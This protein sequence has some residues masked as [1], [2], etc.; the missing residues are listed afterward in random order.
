M[1]NGK[2]KLLVIDG[3]SILNRAF[4][5]IRLLTNRDGLY[6]NAIYGFINI[7]LKQTEQLCPDYCAVAFDL[8][9]PTF[10][11]EMYEQYKAGR[12]GMPDELAVQL[13]YAKRCIELMGYTVLEK[14]GYEAD[15]I[16]GTLAKDASSSGCE[17]YILTGDRDS[18]QLIGEN[19][20]VL[21]ATNSETILYDESKFFEKY[22]IKTTQFV[23]LKALMGDSSDNIPGVAGIGEKTAIK[24]ISEFG[25]LDGLY[26]ALPSDKLSALVNSK[27]QN[28]KEN[29]YLSQKLAKIFDEV[30]EIIMALDDIAIREP[31]KKD[32]LSLFTELEFSGFIKRLNL[33]DPEK[34]SRDTLKI[35]DIDIPYLLKIDSEKILV[36]DIRDGVLT[37]CDG[38]AVYRLSAPLEETEKFFAS[39]RKFI[40]YDCKR[41]YKELEK[42]GVHFRNCMHDVMLGAYVLNPSE[43]SFELS[44]LVM[45]F[46]S[47]TVN[48]ETPFV[49]YIYE[50][51][52]VI[53]AKIKD[54]GM[55]SLMYE[56]EMPLAA[57]LA[58]M[59][60]IGFKI[61]REGL[62]K[63]G[64]E[65][66]QME[67]DLTERIYC[68]AGFEFNINSPKQLGEVLFEK[69]ML[70]ASKKT[71]TGYS[72]NAEILEKLV[73]YH[74]IVADVLEYRMVAKLRSTYVDGLLK[75]ADADGRIH[76]T[77]KQTGTVTGRLSSA[78][79][80]LQNIPIRTEMG[81]RLRKYFV[82]ENKNYLLI[83]ADYSQI[84]LRLLADISKD[85]NMIKA[86]NE[87]E[88]IHTATASSVFGVS[89]DDV[90]PEL[91][92]KAKA[93][94]FG[95][96]Y[97]IGEFSLAADIG[98]TR[99]QAKKYIENYLA[100]YPGVDAYLKEVVKS[101][102]K[103]GFVTTLF[104]RRRYIP[105]LAGQNKNMKNFGERVAMNS[106]IQ[107]T[108][109]DIIKIAM[110]N[111]HRKLKE[112]GIDARLILQVH[113]ELLIEAERGCEEQALDILRYEMENAVQL[114]IPLDV[115]VN[116][117]ED[118]YQ[119]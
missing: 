28:G 39:D 85:A 40:C 21:L 60:K 87:G 37:L 79:P 80:N 102:Y 57:V 64:E 32:L 113:D 50:L 52:R 115:D 81:S 53:E 46:L 3:N 99:L 101:A 100:G 22:G 2:K 86:F 74:P 66:V 111:V 114:S 41:I 67:R 11:H 59:E 9:A 4:Y 98:T 83:D 105:E 23:D 51:Y 62:S 5:G 35:I 116:V 92:K 72:T 47:E 42:F 93:V 89:P 70:P 110:I 44:R 106:P 91:R 54:F 14:A 15:D 12:K 97:G 20:F 33:S 43:G 48:E 78:E 58:D 90:T 45:Q 88:D 95:I 16:L 55:E 8:K 36:L 119:R 63:Y 117:G 108:A 68:Y 118:W 84:E 96:V 1:S 24:L 112:S 56:I 61:D 31:N 10:R 19:S 7:I 27:L 26:D 75:V 73:P 38:D 69:L 103:D 17:A 34:S 30:P 13:P 49:Q 25:S 82:P 77:F 76:T 107:G 94:N 65:L 6:T 104:G 29:A 109:A 71:K 18:L